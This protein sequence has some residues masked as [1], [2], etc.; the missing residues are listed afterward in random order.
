M[1]FLPNNNAA[2]KRRLITEDSVEEEEEDDCLFENQES[3]NLSEVQPTNV[4]APPKEAPKK[5]CRGRPP[6]RNVS[7]TRSVA[8]SSAS[9]LASHLTNL[10][11]FDLVLKAMPLKVRPSTAAAYRKLLENRHGY[12]VDPQFSLTVGPTELVLAFF[13][14][15]V[16]KRTYRKSISM[17][18][19]VRTQIALGNDENEKS[20]LTLLEIAE[21]APSNKNGSKKI[22]DVPLG[23]EAVNQYKKALIV[24]YDYQ[25]EH[26]AIPWASPK[27]NKELLDLIKRYEHDL[28][29]DQ[30]AE[31]LW[32]SNSETGLQEMFSISYRHHMLL[33]DQDLRHLNF[34]DCFCTIVPKKQHNG[35]QQAICL[36]FSLDKGKTLKEGEMKFA[37][38]MRHENEDEDDNIFNLDVENKADPIEFVEEDGKMILKEPKGKGKQK[39]VQSSILRI[40]KTKME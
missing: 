32:A 20:G 19:D 1:S 10:P 40:K 30:N 39:A 12:P 31:N 29:Y 28:V 37:C 22:T 11:E 18:T 34:A 9:T 7:A 23:V 13:K 38:A 14:E 36:V 6:K 27:K 8:E 4:I 33:R 25:F 21:N 17:E 24:V 5:A 26:R 15:S 3:E 2:F 16:L 35:M